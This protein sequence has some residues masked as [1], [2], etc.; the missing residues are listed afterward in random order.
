MTV[1]FYRNEP[2]ALSLLEDWDGPPLTLEYCDQINKLGPMLERSQVLILPGN[3]YTE[4]VAS[5]VAGSPV[6]WIQSTG[7][8]VDG[9]V[10][11]GVPPGVVLTNAR[12]VYTPTIVEHVAGFM[13]TFT[14]QLHLCE[15]FRQSRH[16]SAAI[17]LPDLDTLQSKNLVIYGFG[18]IGRS[19]GA[20]A[21]VFGLNITGVDFA[22]PQENQEGIVRPEKADPYLKAADFLVL[23]LPLTP[24][25]KGLV[26]ENFLGKLNPGC[27]LIN[28][29]RGE[30]VNE[31]AL[32]NALRE[33]M[34][35]GAALDVF[36]IEPLP[37][38]SPLWQFEN[39]IISP[40]V[41]GLGAGMELQ[42]LRLLIKENMEH[43]LKK[44][45]L[46]NVIDLQKGF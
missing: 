28:V 10:K 32:V 36:E 45:P 21:K 7:A 8:G 6:K 23:T 33:K 39:M 26:N 38:S 3:R 4:E 12:G 17:I 41:A 29:S 27:I 5:L 35:R 13:L 46:K 43:F 1:A 42:R 44:Q 34:I 20:M 9:Y 37:E 30:I 18:E 16:W 19:I 25:T 2:V 31:Q 11:A 24:E 14:R 40:H 22:A 15:R